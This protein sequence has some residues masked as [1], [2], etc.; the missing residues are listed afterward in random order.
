M[1]DMFEEAVEGATSGLDR[2]GAIGLAFYRF[3]KDH[4]ECSKLLYMEETPVPCPGSQYDEEC[5]SLNQSIGM[6]MVSAIEQGM[7]DGSI[8]PDVDPLASAL[9]ISSSMQGFLRTLL[10][11]KGTISSLGLEEG[12]MVEQALE[13]YRKALAMP[14]KR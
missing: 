4:P 2:F 6:L 5:R 12:H 11:E 14:D 10:R 3:T 7:K 8:R 1:R 9:V 13:L